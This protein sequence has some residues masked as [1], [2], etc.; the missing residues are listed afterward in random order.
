MRILIATIVHHPLDARI[1]HRQ[2]GALLEAGV[3]VT[4]AAPW[5][6]FNVTA[7]DS[8]APLDL[9]RASGR[10][11]LPAIR[12][13]RRLIRNQAPSHDLVLIHDPDLLLAVTG[14]LSRPVV[15]DVHE[16]TAGAVGDR[17]WIPRTLTYAA[18]AMARRAEHLAERRLHLILAEDDYQ[19][20]FARSHPIVPNVP[21]VAE[22][23]P[24]PG[25]DRAVYVGRLSRGRGVAELL[26]VGDRLLREGV[27][28]DLIGPADADV[29][30]ALEQADAAGHL[31][32]HGFLANDQ[33]LVL[34]RGAMAGLCL[35]HDEP[36]YRPS[37]PT[38]IVEYLAAGVP[39]VATPLPRAAAL[40]DAAGGGM[41]VP[42]GDAA[43]AAE[44]VLALRDDAARREAMGR[45]GH[46]Y[47]ALHHNW[48]IEGPRFVALLRRWAAARPSSSE[49]L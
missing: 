34:V 14:R 15:W 41:V 29:Q 11:R 18:A 33:A 35:L 43:A 45:A 22:H 37:L 5:Q 48:A 16:D 25:G 36:N 10:D 8:V 17:A 26:D 31:R 6:A 47:V 46:A 21:F 9:P 19:E 2:I 27:R 23:V 3:E 12:A 44:A 13:A 42:F 28:L 4:Y 49:N 24:P 20:R 7:P 38:K 32:W 30:A 39:A 1:H 40:V